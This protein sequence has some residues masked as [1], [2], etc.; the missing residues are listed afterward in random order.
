M[1]ADQ[2]LSDLGKQALIGLATAGVGEGFDALAS[3]SGAFGEGVIGKTLLQGL[4]SSTTAAVSGTLGAVT[5]DGGDLVV[6]ATSKSGSLSSAEAESLS[7]ARSRSAACS[8][9]SDSSFRE[10]SSGESK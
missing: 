3:A 7:A 1:Q 4:E 8:T 5:L 2:A 9:N 6:K 10:R